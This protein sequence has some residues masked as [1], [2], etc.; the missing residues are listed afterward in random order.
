MEK[1]DNPGTSSLSDRAFEEIK[2]QLISG[3][4]GPG[5]KLNMIEF[6]RRIGVSQGAVREALSRLQAEGLVLV[7]QNRGYRAA[8]IS[9]RELRQITEARIVIDAECL[10]LAIKC[11]DIDWEGSLLAAC[12][13]AERRRI[14]FDGSPATGEPFATARLAFYATLLEPCANAWLLRMHRLIYAQLARYRHLCLPFADDKKHLYKIDGE[15]IGAVLERDSER[16]VAMFTEHSL[17]IAE[18]IIEVLEEQSS[19]IE[20]E[21][22]PLQINK[23]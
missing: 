19:D 3:G 21:P 5:E 14:L 12:H 8:P 4:I 9:A 23:A 10:R 7:E 18:R 6:S 1:L 16:A 15:F 2:R 11:G 13:R 22:R 17:E 20:A